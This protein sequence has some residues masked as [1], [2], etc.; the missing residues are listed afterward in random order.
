M[1]EQ[2]NTSSPKRIRRKLIAEDEQEII[3]TPTREQW[4]ESRLKAYSFLFLLIIKFAVSVV[5][6][7]AAIIS[8][9]YWYYTMTRWVVF[10][11]CFYFIYKS[12]GSKMI[13]YFVVMLIMFN[14]LHKFIF[15]KNVWHIIDF[16]SMMV[17]VYSAFWDAKKFNSLY[18]NM[19]MKK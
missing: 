18:E 19:P 17:I 3:S 6:I 9:D 14:P 16:I 8:F 12:I 13:P 4:R 1:E 15:H 10:A 11:G 5:L 7:L 2:S